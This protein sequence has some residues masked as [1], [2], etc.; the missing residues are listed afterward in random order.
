[1]S[2]CIEITKSNNNKYKCSKC[3]SGYILLKE[4]N[5][6]KCDTQ[7]FLMLDN[8]DD[9]TCCQEA[10]NIRIFSDNSICTVEDQP[11]YSCKKCINNCVKK[12]TYNELI[13]CSIAT[14]ENVLERDLF[15]CKICIV[16]N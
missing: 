1:M 3:L 5:E 12:E 11:Q 2:N 13:N 6:I 16:D 15:N 7:K 8:T 10:K 4:N 14:V 9:E